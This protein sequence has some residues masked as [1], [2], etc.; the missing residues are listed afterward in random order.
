MLP[1]IRF[2]VGAVLASA[3]MI[4][5][6][7]GLAATVRVAQHARLAPPDATRPLAYDEP[8][9]HIFN[10]SRRFGERGND[11]LLKR[12]AAIPSGNAD[13][14]GAVRQLPPESQPL[15]EIIAPTKEIPASLILELPTGT[16]TKEI[17]PAPVAPMAAAARET[18]QVIPPEIAAAGSERV[19]ALPS[20]AG[21]TAAL[22]DAAAG[23]QEPPV[24][25]LAETPPVAK[26]RPKA[27][28]A[29]KQK[30]AAK[31]RTVRARVVQP[32]ASTGYPVSGGGSTFDNQFFRND[33]RAQ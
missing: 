17:P 7:F 13:L 32:T 2:V 3:V 18:R 21:E 16:L 30:H 29:P 25:T 4:V 9:E 28:V 6:A 26:P 33:R 24:E 23:V 19:A 27:K 12:L 5:T 22:P 11:P 1:D 15:A 20:P 8:I 31:A 14:L 10:P